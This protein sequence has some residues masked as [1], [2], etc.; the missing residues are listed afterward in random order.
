ME[1]RLNLDGTGIA[2]SS[3]GIPFLDHM[4]DVSSENYESVVN[5][6]R[7]IRRGSWNSFVSSENQQHELPPLSNETTQMDYW[8]YNQ[9]IGKKINGQVMNREN[10]PWLLI[11]WLGTYYSVRGISYKICRETHFILR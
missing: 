8:E 7:M 3:T 5:I 1:V 2:D 11:S 9:Y 6:R 4:L 10:I